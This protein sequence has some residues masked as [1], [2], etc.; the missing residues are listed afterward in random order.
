LPGELVF[1]D[2]KPATD[3]AKKAYHKVLKYAGASKSRDACDQRIINEVKTS[4]G[5]IPD[6]Q[7]DVGGWPALNSLPAPTDADKDGMSDVWE[8]ANGLNSNDAED[9]NGDRD[10]D[11]YSNLEEYINSLVEIAL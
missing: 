8:T 5:Q 4:T 6:S 2:D 7:D 9:G 3:T 10:T 1:G 11:G